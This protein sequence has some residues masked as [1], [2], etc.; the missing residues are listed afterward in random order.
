MLTPAEL[1]SVVEVGTADAAPN[2]HAHSP[3]VVAYRG[4]AV[5]RTNAHWLPGNRSGD[6]AVADSWALLL[7]RLRD[8]G[9]ND[10][11]SRAARHKLVR[12]VVGKGIEPKAAVP[13]YDEFNSEVDDL[14][15]E[16]A[17]NE[18]D[19]EGERT[20]WKMQRQ[21]YSEFEEVGEVLLLECHDPSPDRSVSLCYQMLDSEYIDD[22][23]HQP[24]PDSSG[25]RIIRGIEFDARN[26]KVAYWLFDSHPF[27]LEPYGAATS[28]RI[29]AQRVLHLYNAERVS[30]R[31]GV[32]PNAVNMQ[33]ARDLDWLIG[34]ELRKSH[35]QSLFTVA[36]KRAHAGVGTGFGDGGEDS[37]RQGNPLEQL[38]SGIIAEIGPDEAIDMIQSNGGGGPYFDKFVKLLLMQQAA[39]RGLS[40]T[41]LTGDV[42]Q[43]NYSSMRAAGNDDYD[44]IEILQDDFGAC[45]VLP[46]YRTW[47]R[48]A[49]AA[50][51]I[52]TVP[53][54]TFAGNVA[55]FSRC[56]L[57]FPGRKQVD[58][59]A[60]TNAALLRIFGGLGTWKDELAKIG[61]DYREVFAQLK[62]EWD[63]LEAHGMKAD[64]NR[65]AMAL[66][67]TIATGGKALDE[68][69]GGDAD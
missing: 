57:H 6:A 68:A 41:G 46:T 15:A 60:E 61:L 13:G 4:A 29:P 32:S 23:K 36:Y 51:R 53:A 20:W 5:H 14:F 34:C 40:Y 52:R 31:R 44:L 66:G 63:L 28:R 27:G 21:L 48:H 12:R 7:A 37:D 67:T 33:N 2:I 3:S 62:A 59:T 26:R 69:G 25:H 50:G 38:G 10:V 19:A 16:W 43:A 17:E 54:A 65:L 56:S 55:R 58:V 1:C 22:A 64:L 39:G 8:L 49:A 47:L 18:A 24:W 45:P 9:R 30:Q 35:I 42:S 11:W